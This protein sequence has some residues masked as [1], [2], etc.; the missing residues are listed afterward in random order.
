MASQIG[1]GDQLDKILLAVV[2]H[3]QCGQAEQ[4]LAEILTA[5]PEIGANNGFDPFAMGIAIET[6]QPTLIHLIGQGHRRHAVI[7]RAANQRLDLL[8]AIEH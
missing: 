6:H 5:H 7:S 4:F 2:V 1:A 3:R 8:Q